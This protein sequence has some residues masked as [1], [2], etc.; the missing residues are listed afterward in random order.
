VKSGGEE[1]VVKQA[2]R[3]SQEKLMDSLQ[4][5]HHRDYGKRNVAKD[6]SVLKWDFKKG[7]KRDKRLMYWAKK[8]IPI[9]TYRVQKREGGEP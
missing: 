1:G 9:R 7:E 3:A 2:R 5:T 6:K 4:K 8:T